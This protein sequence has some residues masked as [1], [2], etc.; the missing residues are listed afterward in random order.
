MGWPLWGQGGYSLSYSHLKQPSCGSDW[1]HFLSVCVRY[2]DKYNRCG[3]ISQN[4]FNKRLKKLFLQ[5]NVFLIWE[6]FDYFQSG[7]VHHPP[8]AFLA[9]V[10]AG[11]AVVVEVEGVLL[12]L[13]RLILPSTVLPT[14]LLTILPLTLLRTFDDFRIILTF[15]KFF[16]IFLN[17]CYFCRKCCIQQ[18]LWCRSTFWK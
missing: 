1:K 16:A 9:D 13:V 3:W 14:S 15:S 11:I 18:H 17:F 8:S 2:E 12:L 6:C 5:E 7:K 10:D 4:L